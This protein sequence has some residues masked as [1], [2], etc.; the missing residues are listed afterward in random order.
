M[1]S[2]APPSGAEFSGI[3]LEPGGSLVVTALGL[4]TG[5]AVIRIN[6]ATGEQTTVASGGLLDMGPLGIAVDR[7]GSLVVG[8]GIFGNP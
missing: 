6:P 3:A 8:G 7:D 2:A 4:D 1:I 5:N